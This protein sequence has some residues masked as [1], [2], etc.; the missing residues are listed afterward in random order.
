[1][2]IQYSIILRVWSELILLSDDEQE[3][4]NR[5]LLADEN[6]LRQKDK[7]PITSLIN[8]QRSIFSEKVIYQH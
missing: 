2:S 4:L 6:S 7:E 1:M 3:E 8:Y 5:P